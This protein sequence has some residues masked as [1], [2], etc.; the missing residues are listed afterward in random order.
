M[1]EKLKKAVI[2]QIGDKESLKDVCEHGAEGGYSGFTYYSDTVKFYNKN[3][4]EIWEL[5]VETAE[6]LGE[7][8]LTMIAGFS[9]AKNVANGDTFKNLMSW[10]A[11]EEVARDVYPEN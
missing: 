11:L 4:P 10:F 3:E 6:S 7:N 2:K 5:L 8:V 9:G 1:N